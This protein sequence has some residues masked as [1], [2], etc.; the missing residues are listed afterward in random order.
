MPLKSGQYI[1]LIK[2]FRRFDHLNHFLDGY[3]YCNTPEYYRTSK[4]VGVSDKNESCHL[5][6]RS[7]RGDTPFEVE[8][9][10]V[11]IGPASDITVRQGR[12]EGWL[13]CW[14]ALIVP[15]TDK[16]FKK[17]SNDLI[18]LKEEFGPHY[19]FINAEQSHDFARRIKESVN[20]T[21]ETFAI[22]YTENKFT[23]Q[24]IQTKSIEY[25]YQ[26]EFRFVFSECETNELQHNQWHVP[27]GFRD[28]FSINPKIEIKASHDD[29]LLS[30]VLESS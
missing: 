24:S 28:L 4:D 23:G 26:R 11:V 25:S 12:K 22:E 2:F 6:I 18:K 20:T 19:V 17:F 29:E 10:G 3:L 9:D 8:V 13:H 15:S 21:V 7:Q 16:E 1:G 27:N 14:V 5:S 30:I